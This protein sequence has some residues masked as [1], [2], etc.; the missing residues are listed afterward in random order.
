M[1]KT[2]FVYILTNKRNRVLYTGIT[3]NIEYRMLQH[4]NKQFWGFTEKY[5]VNKLV[6]YEIFSNPYDA[7]KREKHIKRWPRQKKI[8]LINKSNP[9]WEDLYD[10]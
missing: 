5:N 1:N 4:K 6:Y 3:G 10:G 9:N 2:Y 8:D 7:I